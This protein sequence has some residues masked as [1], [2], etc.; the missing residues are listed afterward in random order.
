MVDVSGSMGNIL[1]S[2][3]FAEWYARQLLRKSSAIVAADEEL[4]FEGGG[5]TPIARIVGCLSERRTA[6]GH[7]VQ[8]LCNQFDALVIATD[9]DGLKELSL[10]PLLVDGTNLQDGLVAVTVRNGS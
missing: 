3:A 5:G 9:A 7:L 8:E 10:H 4:R 1:K 6:L 2:Q